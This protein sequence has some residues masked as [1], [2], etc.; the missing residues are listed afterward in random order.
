MRARSYAYHKG[1]PK[2]RIAL[3]RRRVGFERSTNS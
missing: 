3:Q 2:S 1:G